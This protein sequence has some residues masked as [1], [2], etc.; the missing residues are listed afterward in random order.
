MAIYHNYY[1]KNNTETSWQVNFDEI[2]PIVS[3]FPIYTRESITKKTIPTRDTDG[4]AKAGKTHRL[5]LGIS[6]GGGEIILKFDYMTIS[7]VGEIKTIFDS[8]RNSF[9]YYD[10]RRNKSYLAKFVGFDYEY[11]S[12]TDH[13]TASLKLNIVEEL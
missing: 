3:P 12:G 2:E 4:T 9:I 10:G 6:Q 5:D 1:I 11:I 7:K 8:V 13:V